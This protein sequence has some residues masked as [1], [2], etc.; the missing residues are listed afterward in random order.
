MSSEKELK[1][2]AEAVNMKAGDER[3]QAE[4]ALRAARQHRAWKE[5]WPCHVDGAVYLIASLCID[6]YVASFRTGIV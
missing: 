5:R 4:L 6:S 3:L 2:A 1:L